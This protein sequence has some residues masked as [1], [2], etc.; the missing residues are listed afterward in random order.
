MLENISTF[1][2][3]SD[4]V[5]REQEKMKGL[6]LSQAKDLINKYIN[7]GQLIYVIVGDAAT[8]MHRLKDCGLG[9]PVQLD[10]DAVPVTEVLN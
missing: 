1:D 10:R 2:L 5:V 9:T 8:Q 6:T 7:P 3:P 4:Y